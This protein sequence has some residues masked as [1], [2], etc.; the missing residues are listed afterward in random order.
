MVKIV[1]VDGVEKE[2]K[3]VSTD[4][5]DAVDKIIEVGTKEPATPVEPS[6]PEP[7]VVE[8]EETKVEVVPYKTVRRD[9]ADLEKGKENVVQ[10]GKAG[11]ITTVVK[12]VSVDGVEK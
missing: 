4:K 2:R 1:I 5:V 11:R 7:K 3:V 6:K 8:K 12:I 10:E 9:N